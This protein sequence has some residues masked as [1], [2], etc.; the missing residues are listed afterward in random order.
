MCLTQ[1][2]FWALE[3]LL[4][5]VVTQEERCCWPRNGLL[6]SQ[7]LFREL[8]APGAGPVVSDRPCGH[9]SVHVCDVAGAAVCGLGRWRA[10]SLSRQALSAIPVRLGPRLGHFV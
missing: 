2:T 3:P 4:G 5:R 1:C 10:Q 7:A 9:M 6:V 8:L